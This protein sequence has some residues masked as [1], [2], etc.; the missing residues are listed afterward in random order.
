MTKIDSTR[1]ATSAVATDS[2]DFGFGLTVADL[3]CRDGLVK[4]DQAFL[5]FLQA[6]DATLFTNL[7]HART[8]PDELEAKDES[9]LL[10]AIAPWAE[11]FIAKLFGIEA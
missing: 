10:I 4:L 5:D 7:I 11:D 1:H 8:C 3:Y 6:G 2:P 9:A